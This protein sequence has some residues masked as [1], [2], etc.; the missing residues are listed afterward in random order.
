MR[1]VAVARARQA[2]QSRTILSI[3]IIYL[4]INQAINIVRN[5][6]VHKCSTTSLPLSLFPQ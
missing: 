3:G 2:V 5:G 4:H 6:C 1:I